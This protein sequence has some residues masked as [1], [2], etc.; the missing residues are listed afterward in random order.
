MC[1]KLVIFYQLTTSHALPVASPPYFS[2]LLVN[3]QIHIHW[4]CVPNSYYLD[5]HSRR[6]HVPSHL[7]S[8]PLHQLVPDC[9]GLLDVTTRDPR[10]SS[11][12]RLHPRRSQT[13]RLS[14]RHVL[15]CLLRTSVLQQ[16][17]PRWLS[18]A[19]SRRD[20]MDTYGLHSSHYGGGPRGNS[21][22][23][24]PDIRAVSRFALHVR[25]A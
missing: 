21:H 12:L 8:D 13:I 10:P 11:T 23:P 17:L 19:A 24:S 14:F 18:S 9:R 4:L 20:P 1:L 25:V 15:V 16:T 2:T 22:W 7:A 6:R 5:Y 3:N